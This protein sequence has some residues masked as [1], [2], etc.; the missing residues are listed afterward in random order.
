MLLRTQVVETFQFGVMQNVKS[1]LSV[2]CHVFIDGACLCGS[3]SQC[4]HEVSDNHVEM[5][6]SFLSLNGLW[7]PTLLIRTANK[8]STCLAL[9]P[10][11][12]SL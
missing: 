4:A 12:N 6:L 7:D 10:A 3:M 8:V 5:V 11:L 9:S 2:S 1:F